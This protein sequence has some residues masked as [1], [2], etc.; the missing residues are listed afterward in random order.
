M[1]PYV[2]TRWYRAPDVLILQNYSKAVD[3][4]SVGCILA[5]M[6]SS[7]PLFPGSDCKFLFIEIKLIKF[8]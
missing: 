7:L 1:T 6:F 5:E 4:W 2:V 8:L 3:I